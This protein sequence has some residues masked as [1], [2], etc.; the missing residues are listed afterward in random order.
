M[1]P[2]QRAKAEVYASL[3]M[4]TRIAIMQDLVD[5]AQTLG[6]PMIASGVMLAATRIVRQADR[7]R[8][9][10]EAK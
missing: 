3:P 9:E 6:D 4:Q 5:F 2:A 10:K 8:R 1:N 7:L